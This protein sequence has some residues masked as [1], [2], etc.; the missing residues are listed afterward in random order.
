MNEEFVNEFYKLFS[1]YD[2]KYYIGS[3]EQ[4]RLLL[5]LKFNKYIS[6]KLINRAFNAFISSGLVLNTKTTKRIEKQIG[7]KI[8]KMRAQKVYK[9]IDNDNER[10]V[11]K[12]LY[13]IF[14]DMD[15]MIDEVVTSDDIKKLRNLE[16]QKRITIQKLLHMSY[17]PEQDFSDVGLLY[18]IP[19][20]TI[21]DYIK[22]L[23][24]YD[25]KAKEK[26][27]VINDKEREEYLK[28]EKQRQLQQKIFNNKI[29]N[30][31]LNL[32]KENLRIEGAL[33]ITISSLMGWHYTGD[34]S[35]NSNEIGYIHT[36]NIIFED[37]IIKINDSNCNFTF[38]IDK[39][40]INLGKRL[41]A[42]I[43]NNIKLV[44]NVNESL[45]VSL[46]KLNI[47]C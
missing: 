36:N 44:I 3:K 39:V 28:I 22:T 14:Q 12:S 7:K 32:L 33:N 1:L 35:Y 23:S 30:E 21:K 29:I 37:N 42:L 20:I 34:Y 5:Q 31:C 16:K 17:G 11:I 25:P 27:K 8:F 46:R 19:R 38:K 4:A 10:K 43:S 13:V 15:N 47:Y 40:F 26:D 24:E 9:R 41:M 18:D 6:V 45:V 2:N